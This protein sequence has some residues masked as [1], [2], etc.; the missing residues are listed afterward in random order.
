MLH[1]KRL[2]NKTATLLDSIHYN[3]LTQPVTFLIVDPYFITFS[4]L[5]IKVCSPHFQLSK[6]PLLTSSHF[7]SFA[8]IPVTVPLSSHVS[9]CHL[10]QHA[11]WFLPLAHCTV[12]PNSRRGMRI[13]FKWIN[14]LRK[15]GKP[16]TTIS[17]A[18][19]T[20]RYAQAILIFAFLNDTSLLYLNIYYSN[21]KQTAHRTE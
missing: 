8:F 7:L 13:T 20:G 6:H 2:N 9:P 16:W 1:N 21:T 3:F 11:W 14:E 4:T 12:T 5:F 18:C 19:R 17:F 15:K 10:S